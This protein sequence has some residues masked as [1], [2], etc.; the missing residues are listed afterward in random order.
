MGTYCHTL[1]T[2][3][4]SGETLLESGDLN[5]KIIWAFYRERSARLQVR[6]CQRISCQRGNFGTAAVNHRLQRESAWSAGG[7]GGE[8]P[9]YFRYFRTCQF[10][11]RAELCHPPSL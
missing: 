4:G 6:L 5:G 3:A 2:S 9:A 8:A 1:V 7:Y 10:F 11:A